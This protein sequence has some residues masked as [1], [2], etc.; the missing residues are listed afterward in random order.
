MKQSLL[1]LSLA[2]IVFASCNN[3]PKESSENLT[4]SDTSKII[5]DKMPISKSICYST[6]TGKDSVKMKLEIIDKVV[7]GNLSY[8]FYQKDSNKGEV[9]GVLKGDTLMADYKFMSEGK[10]SVRQVIFLIQDSV[11]IEGYGKMDN[12]DGRMIFKSNKE[13]TF[14]KGIRLHKVDCD[15]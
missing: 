10:Q 11:A 9:E 7:T 12:K 3:E 13:I 1:V 2:T 14:G 4:V 8:K 5:E 6:T 15:K